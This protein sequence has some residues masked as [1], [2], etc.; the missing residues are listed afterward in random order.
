AWLPAWPSG[1]GRS[2]AMPGA[3]QSMR[4][5]PTASLAIFATE[6]SSAG[7]PGLEMSVATSGMDMSAGAG[8]EILVRGATLIAGPTASG[9]S[10]LALDLAVKT[11]AVIVN[12]DSMQVYS[13]LSLITAR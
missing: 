13:V 1:S 9:K 10:A 11:G 4:L 7:W 2:Q 12:A 3:S 5:A 6:G 8:R